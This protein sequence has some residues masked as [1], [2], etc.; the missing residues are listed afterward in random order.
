MRYGKNCKGEKCRSGK[1][2]SIQQRWKMQEWKKAGVDIFHSCIF[3]LPH[4][5]LPLPPNRQRRVWDAE[6]C[7]SVGSVDCSSVCLCADTWLH[8]NAAMFEQN[9]RCGYALK[10][11]VM[12]DK[13]HP[14]YNRFNPFDKDTCGPS[15]PAVLTVVVRTTTSGHL[16]FVT[17]NVMCVARSSN[18]SPGALPISLWLC[19]I[20]YVG[21]VS[22]VQCAYIN[23]LKTF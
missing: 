19:S 22:V 12:W 7:F 11:R 18:W 10:P 15:N 14:L 6:N 9:G 4:F 1:C 23:N 21:T 13:N 20:Q 3:L 5:Q 17:H 16:Y 8:I 2:R